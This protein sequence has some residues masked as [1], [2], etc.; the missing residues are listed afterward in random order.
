MKIRTKIA[1]LQMHEN[2]HKNVNE[3]KFHIFKQIFMS[4][5]DGLL[6][7]QICYSLTLLISYGF[8]SNLKWRSSSFRLHQIFPILTDK[9]LFPPNSTGPWPQF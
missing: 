6:K 3:N 4:F 5:Y 1:K 8:R 9:M 7:Q 2:L